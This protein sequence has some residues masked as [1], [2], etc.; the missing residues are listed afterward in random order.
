MGGVGYDHLPGVG[1]GGVVG[2]MK[3]NLIISLFII[4]LIAAG[5]IGVVMAIKS[6]VFCG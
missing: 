1:C 5:L 3:S 2:A 6:G 4:W